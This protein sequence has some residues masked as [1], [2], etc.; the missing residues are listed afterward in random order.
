MCTHVYVRVAMLEVF[1][2]IEVVR[3]GRDVADK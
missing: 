1:R 3:T 2:H